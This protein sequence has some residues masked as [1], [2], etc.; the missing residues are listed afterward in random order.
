MRNE[1]VQKSMAAIITAENVSHEYPVRDGRKGEMRLVLNSINIQI[2]KGEFITLVGPTGCGKSTLLR[3]ILGSEIPTAG[4]VWMEDQVIEEPDRDR[5]IVL[6]RYTIFPHMTVEQNVMLGL[7]LEQFSLPKLCLH[8]FHCHRKRKSFRDKAGEYL[9]RVG[10][11]EHRHKFP[12]ELSGGMKQRVAI[13]Q[14]MVMEPKV[15][16]MDEPF[17]ALDIGTREAMQVF[18]LEQWQSEHQTVVFVTHDLEEAIYIGTRLVVISQYYSN[19]DGTP[20][21][22][23]TVVKDVD[24]PWVH[25]RPTSVKATK[26]FNEL[27]A[28]VRKEGL[29]PNYLQRIREFDLS[30]QNKKWGT[31]GQ[32]PIPLRED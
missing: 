11:Y 18:V 7:E 25:P 2:T 29:D 17:G 6:Q 27:M 31:W 5:G 10:L 8:P 9:E 30:H 16:L 24:I 23:A 4:R 13:A 28:E 15:L 19:E 21:V 32:S 3:L 20:G 26:D 1:E 22:G 12:H 14:A